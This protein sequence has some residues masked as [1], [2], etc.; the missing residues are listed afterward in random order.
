MGLKLLDTLT[1]DQGNTVCG[2]DVPQKVADK[3]F[4]PFI[5]LLVEKIGEMNYRA[6]D[7]SLK[8]LGDLLRHPAVEGRHAIEAIMDITEKPPGPA[9]APWRQL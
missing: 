7:I 8:A 9:K 5:K 2:G 4:R 1:T 3:A 6:R